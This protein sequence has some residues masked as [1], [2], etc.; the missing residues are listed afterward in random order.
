[1]VHLDVEA[2]KNLTPRLKLYFKMSREQINKP[3]TSDANNLK[4]KCKDLT[5]TQK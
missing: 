5:L 2:S 3:K 4:A 1:M